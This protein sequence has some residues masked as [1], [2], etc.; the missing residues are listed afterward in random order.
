M[1]TKNRQ[2]SD[3]LDVSRFICEALPS[4]PPVCLRHLAKPAL[5]GKAG[6]LPAEREGMLIGT[7]S[8]DLIDKNGFMVLKSEIPG[9]K[10]KD[11]KT[12]VTHDEVRFSSKVEQAKEERKENYY[13]CERVYSSW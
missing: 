3:F 9:V 10:K 1:G 6:L 4:P 12:T 13:H 11:I 5:T 7:P 2:I 8:V